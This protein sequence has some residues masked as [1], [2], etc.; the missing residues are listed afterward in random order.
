M[1]PFVNNP[2]DHR[3]WTVE[4]STRFI[5]EEHLFNMDHPTGRRLGMGQPKAANR[6]TGIVVE[7]FKI[8]RI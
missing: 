6:Y 7:Q 3:I 1:L 2:G 5:I 8:H 4:V